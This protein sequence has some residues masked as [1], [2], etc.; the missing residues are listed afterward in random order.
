[1]GVMPCVPCGECITYVQCSDLNLEFNA[2]G[3]HAQPIGDDA[4]PRTWV[5]DREVVQGGFN[6]CRQEYGA[7][8]AGS[9]DQYGR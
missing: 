3:G 4:V 7:N 1:M 5:Q 9:P 2:N 8:H 6:L